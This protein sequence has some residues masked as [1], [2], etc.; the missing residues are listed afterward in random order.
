MPHW[1]SGDLE[2]AMLD[3][4]LETANDQRL[5]RAYGRAEVGFS[6]RDGRTVLKRL[7]QEGQAKIRL[8]KVHGTDEPFAVFINT[9]GGVTGGDRLVLAAD[10]AP[11]AKATVTGQAAERIYKSSA[12]PGTIDI[13]LTVGAG[14]DAAWLPQE[15]ILFNGSRLNRRTDVQMSGDG[16]LLMV[17]MLVFGRTAMGETVRD[18]ALAD[19]WRIRRDGRLVFA[20]S[21]RLRGDASAILARPAIGA[22]AVAVATLLLAAPDAERHLDRLRA[23]LDNAASEAGASA[24]DG[25]LVARL[26]SPSARVLRAD[27]VRILESFRGRALP[28]PWYC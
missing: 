28:R 22:N 8:P 6:V 20:D 16:R 11:A 24:F 10:W 15:T 4:P 26:L 17:E 13:R 3:R 1:S 5:Q 27:L 25:I 19:H 2:H 21:V 23:T 12:G 18:C 7:Y 9:A 14:A